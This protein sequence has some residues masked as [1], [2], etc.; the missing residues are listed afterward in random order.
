MRVY[1]F[2]NCQLFTN[3]L[4]GTFE[5]LYTLEYTVNGGEGRE[6]TNRDEALN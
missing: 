1:I 2:L 5:L 4:T 6:G 3:T